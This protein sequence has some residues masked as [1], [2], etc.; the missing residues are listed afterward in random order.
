M[1]KTT[2]IRPLPACSWGMVMTAIAVAVCPA[3]AQ[4]Q[5]GILHRRT[6]A[7][8]P[9]VVA[10][11]IPLSAGKAVA[12][13]NVPPPADAAAAM[14]AVPGDGLADAVPGVAVE[15]PEGVV[16]PPGAAGSVPGHPGGYVSGFDGGVAE[17]PLP[18]PIGPDDVVSIQPYPHHPFDPVGPPPVS[19]MPEV[20]MAQLS[21]MSL[22]GD[23]TPMAAGPRHEGRGPGLRFSDVV[24]FASAAAPVAGPP[25]GSSL[26]AGPRGLPQRGARGLPDRAVGVRPQGVAAPGPRPASLTTSAAGRSR[27]AMTP[28]PVGVG[29]AAPQPRW[30]DRLRFAFPSGR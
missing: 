21:V 7:P 3:V 17:V 23:V 10:P 9:V 2:M 16:G 30:R 22:P 1:Q 24:P 5:I 20:D 19:A 14:P 8:A 27:A 29:R 11:A 26:G 13:S 28:Q 25:R 12:V 18:A 4:A 15:V 6:Y